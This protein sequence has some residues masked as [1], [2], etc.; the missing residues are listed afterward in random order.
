MHEQTKKNTF[1]R[2]MGRFR[3]NPDVTV[4]MKFIQTLGLFH[5]EV[6]HKKMN[7]LPGFILDAV[8]VVG[9]EYISYVGTDMKL[10]FYKAS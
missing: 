4:D 7:I 3:S 6:Y 5:I 10:C 9:S 2:L 1:H 8:N